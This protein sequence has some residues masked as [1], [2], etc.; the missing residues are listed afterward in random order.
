MTRTTLSDHLA[1]A[2]AH[3]GEYGGAE[4]ASRFGDP[5]AEFAALRSACGV[6]DLG[7][8]AKLAATG[9]DRVRWMNGMVTGNVRDLAQNHGT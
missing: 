2:G 3:F 5:Q 6:F 7:W 8:R 4:T 1:A 9:D